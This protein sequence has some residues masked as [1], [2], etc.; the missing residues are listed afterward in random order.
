MRTLDLIIFD[1]DGTLVDSRL[2]L[3][4]S[5]NAALRDLG[6]PLKTP[7]QII[8]M[9]G[10]GTRALV[11]RAV[12]GERQQFER[13]FSIFTKD[14]GE[15]LLDHTKL[16]PGAR[17]ALARLEGKKLAVMSNKRQR[18]CDAIL[19]G[20]D[21][22]RL[23][24]MIQGGDAPH[25]KKPNPAP[26]L[27]IARRLGVPPARACMVGDSPVDVAAGKAAGMRTVGLTEGF[28]P[29]GQMATTG[30]DLLLST[31]AGLSQASIP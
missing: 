19:R 1:L 28:T 24:A 2:D 12:G 6:L 21:V 29:A 31:I 7:E 26:L 30:A 14:Y 9:I 8:G 16:Y 4:H 13:A 20:L 25:G 15:H 18:F 11:E 10:N 17:E 5:V 22:D 23:F 3:T 27:E